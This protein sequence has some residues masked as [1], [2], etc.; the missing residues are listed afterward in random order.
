MRYLLSPPSAV[1]RNKDSYD[2]TERRAQPKK[3][4]ACKAARTG[5]PERGNQNGTSIGLPGQGYQH[6]AANTGLLKYDSQDRTERSQKRTARTALREWEP[7]L[8]NDRF[9]N[10]G[11]EPTLSIHRV[12]FL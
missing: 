3:G 5:Q 7:T 1:I 2:R 12:I 11:V 9:K 4:Q 8:S 6:K 10:E